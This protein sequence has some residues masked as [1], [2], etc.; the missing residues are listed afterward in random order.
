MLSP[1][2]LCDWLQQYMFTALRDCVP[3]M[4]HA[5]HA[6]SCDQLLECYRKEIMEVFHEVRSGYV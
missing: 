2:P 6:E 4:L 3:C 1:V 5:K